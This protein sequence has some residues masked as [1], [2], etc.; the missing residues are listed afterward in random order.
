[1]PLAIEL[2]AARIKLFPPQALLQRL[3]SRLKLLTGGAKDRPTRHQTLRGAIDWSYSLLTEEEQLLFA[4]LSVFAGGCTFE[5]VEMVCNADADLDLLEGM[6][7]LVD[8]SLGNIVGQ[9][10]Q[11]ERA[12]AFYEESLLLW[13]EVGNRLG[14]ARTLG[15]LGLIVQR[16]GDL[17]TA[18]ERWEEALILFREMGDIQN[19]AL[20]LM[21]LSIPAQTQGRLAQA[22]AWLEESLAL[23]RS[24]GAKQRMALCL[25]NMA[26]VDRKQGR[27]QRAREL[28]REGLVL[29]RELGATYDALYLIGEV[30]KLAYAE[31]RVEQ[32]VCLEGA[33]AV[34]RESFVIPNTPS[35]RAETDERLAKVRATLGEEHFSRAWERGQAMSLEET[36]ACALEENT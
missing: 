8:K 17:D 33:D 29:A 24:Q 4:R 23:F 30:A 13:R 16:Q 22:E 14:G 11:Y 31:R 32:G 10:G 28:L 19:I 1:L 20:T 2:A 7:S 27:Y 26:S 18:I 15:N 12:T 25:G 3:S 34:L 9:Q 6:T 35:R 21:N 36:I 5:A